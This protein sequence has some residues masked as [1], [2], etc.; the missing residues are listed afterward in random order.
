MKLLKQTPVIAFVVLLAAACWVPEQFE[1]TLNIDKVRWY[2]F[3][4]E[5][6]IAYT[7]A[8]DEIQKTGRLT[9]AHEDQLK[10]DVTKL[11][12]E[13][14][15]LSAEYAGRGRVKIKIRE[16]GLAKPGEKFF[17][18]FAKFEQGPDGALRI[19]GPK[20]SANDQQQ[21]KESGLKVDGTI[22][23]TTELLV[24]AHNA[25]STPWFGG[26]VGSYKWHLTR[27]STAVPTVTIK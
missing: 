4:Y 27:S 9:Q 2:T 7:G 8:L 23:M 13:E 21:M 6:T 10:S 17:M 26:K 25:S 15:V 3:T 5:G 1:A 12:K 20:M 16:E 22:R 24:I 18:D 19:V 11:L 14:G